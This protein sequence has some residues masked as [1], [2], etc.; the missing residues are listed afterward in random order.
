MT[1]E[2]PGAPPRKRR[3]RILFVA[4]AATLAHVARPYTLAKGLDPDR[5]DIHFACAGTYLPLFPDWP[6]PRVPIE[7]I[8]PKLFT[9][10]LARGAR[11]YSFEMLRQYAKEDLRV[12]ERVRPDVVVGD[13][14]LSL[15]ASAR[16]AG[17]PYVTVTNA[18]WSPHAVLPAFPLP[19]LPMTRL[20]GVRAASAL[21]RAVRP[22]AFAWHAV[23]LNRL[24][25]Q[26]GLPAPGFD[27]RRVY[28]DADVTLYAD[29]PQ[30]VPTS[31]L[32]ASH[33][34][35][36]PVEWSPSI[37]MPELSLRPGQRLV[38]ITMGSSGSGALLPMILD[39]LSPLDCHVA[40]ATAGASLGNV[41]GNVTVAEYL[42]GDRVCARASLV[43]CNG[44]SPTSQQAL[45][46]GVPVLGIP[47]NLDQHLNMHF[48]EA[49]GAG[50]CARPET[51]TP[52]S[53]RA[54]A[55]KLLDDPSFGHRARELQQAFSACAPI[56]QF[57]RALASAVSFRGNP[58]DVPGGAGPRAG[59]PDQA[60]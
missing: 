31:D 52:S 16:V 43:I 58:D 6:W 12:M 46:R 2:T 32:P 35:L 11:L 45:A 40:V 1:D 8:S 25:R 51:A 21:F 59:D 53:L 7:S 9:A 33:R 41:S 5:W 28:T 29:I 23:P 15:S 30:L 20:L 48:V 18:Y 14:R 44:G 27:L 3:P 38:Y 37:A 4:E 49:Y 10:R 54:T 47:F 36:G 26:Y 57:E 55:L 60:F 17:V 39:A 42:P 24:R 50:L 34:Y 22:A 13:F 56:E 19:D